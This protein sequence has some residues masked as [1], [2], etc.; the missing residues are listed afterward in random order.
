MRVTGIQ[1][2]MLKMFVHMRIAV[3]VL[4]IALP[5]VLVV[6]GWLQQVPT[7]GSLSAYYHATSACG[8]PEQEAQGGAPCIPG[9]GPMRNWFVGTLFSIGIAMFALKGF[10]RWED[11]ALD[12]AGILAPCIAL[13]PMYW[14]G[15]SAHFTIHSLHTPIAMAFFACI[16]FTAIFC[17]E[18]TLKEM[19]PMPDREKV[20][21]FYR[22][23]YW[24]FAALMIVAPGTAWLWTTLGHA[25]DYQ[26]LTLEVAGIWAFGSY[27]LFKTWELKRSNVEAR[28]LRGELMLDANKLQ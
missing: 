10:S 17:S 23:W 19:P 20:I 2:L 25:S 15:T 4:G 9:A 28:A 26:T 7:T 22:H 1:Q 5:V 18:K 14:P 3:G 11:Y 13:I 6:G 8:S 16:A 21:R 27:W 12:A 24:F